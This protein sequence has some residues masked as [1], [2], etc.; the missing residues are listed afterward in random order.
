MTKP[1][2]LITG[3]TVSDAAKKILSDAGAEVTYMSGPINEATMLAQLAAADF[4]AILLRGSPPLTKKVLDAA[5]H[6][7]IIA[8]HGVGVDSVDIDAATARGIVVV[9]AGDANADAVA[10]QSIMFMLALARELP[11]YH[12]GLREGKW[13]K[14]A[15]V[16]REFRGRTVGIVGYG[17]IGSRTARLAR[18]LGA[19][20][21]FYGLHPHGLDGEA[22]PDTIN[23]MADERLQALRAVRPTGPYFLA[24]YCNGGYV[25]IEM[26]RRLVA[27]GER[28]PV[29]VVIDALAPVIAASRRMPAAPLNTGDTVEAQYW[30]VMSA[31][32][33]R[34]YRGKLVVMRSE[35]MRSMPA[36]L[37]WSKIAPHAETLSIAGDHFGVITRDVATTAARLRACLD[38]A[39]P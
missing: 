38:S 2:V 20:Q 13:E 30:R 5:K 24:G 18:A 4:N 21:P 26:A 37:G 15:R 10:E 17:Q 31:H 12:R 36:C 11:K 25:A 22:I 7:K 28:V 27:A 39:H 33:P 3:N 14:G 9:T 23:A 6:L 34:A 8:K 29:V 16:G 19:D 35:S 32:N 1:V